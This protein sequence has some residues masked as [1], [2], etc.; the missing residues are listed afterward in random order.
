[1]DISSYLKWTGSNRRQLQSGSSSSHYALL[2][3][4]AYFSEK[5]TGSAW[6]EQNGIVVGKKF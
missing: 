3:N 4:L 1:M 5:K 2:D 6:Y